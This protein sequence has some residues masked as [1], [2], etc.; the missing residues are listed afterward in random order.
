[1]KAQLALDAV[2][3][4]IKNQGPHGLKPLGVVDDALHFS[5]PTI[6]LSEPPKYTMGEKVGGEGCVCVC[7]CV[8]MCACVRACV[9]TCVCAC[10]RACVHVYVVCVVQGL[11]ACMLHT[12]VLCT[13]HAIHLFFKL[14]LKFL[15]HSNYHIAGNVCGNNILRFTGRK[16]LVCGFNVCGLILTVHIN[17][18]R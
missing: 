2:T 11:F 1:M 6:S 16:K 8:C 12:Y 5:V 3:A 18:M 4:M 7:V 9:C 10:V 14:R 17:Y 13:V 15:T